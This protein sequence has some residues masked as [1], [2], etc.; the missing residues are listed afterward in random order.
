VSDL[1]RAVI[2]IDGTS[3]SGKS[4]VSRA[5]ATTLGLDY[6]D[7]GAMYRAMA[8]WVIQE[9][10]EPQDHE[11]VGQRCHEPV[12][13]S[14]TDPADP[15]ILVDGEDVSTA[16]RGPQATGAVSHVAAVPAV[17]TRLVDLQRQQVADSAEQ[18]RGIVVEGRDI[19]RVVLPDADLKVYLTADPAVRAARRAAQD[20]ALAH[21][22]AGH[23]ATEESLRMRDHL[24]STRAVSP[25]R[26]AD[27]AY[28]IDASELT[29][30]EVVDAVL[31]LLR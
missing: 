1:S 9:G 2:A 18:G 4:S 16:I 31:D 12:L 27:D 14:V 21:G 11:A 23:A 3:G 25:L 10:L 26:R 15:R 5:V 29:L 20:Q 7:T 30:D 28:E 8:W 24:D 19:A 6:L 13:Q 22:S 17:R